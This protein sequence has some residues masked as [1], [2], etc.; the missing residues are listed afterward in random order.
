[1]QG[2]LVT[3]LLDLE[4][5]EE[6]LAAGQAQ[7][8]IA[9]GA[10]GPLLRGQGFGQVHLVFRAAVD[11]A[12]YGA[13]SFQRDQD[14]AVLAADPAGIP[15]SPKGTARRIE[16]AIMQLGHG[17]FCQAESGQGGR[18]QQLLERLLIRDDELGLDLHDDRPPC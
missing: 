16:I 18:L 8:Y 11:S 12:R 5:R 9:G 13:Q 6:W 14:L 4:E 1:M 10:D 3:G 15:A 17:S 7:G 2:T